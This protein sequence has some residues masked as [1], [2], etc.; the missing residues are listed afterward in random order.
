MPKT[1][2][3]ETI[4]DCFALYLKYNGE[5]LDLVEREMHDLGWVGF[6]KEILFN[7]GLGKNQRDGWI[8]RF[9]WQKSLELKIATAGIAAQTS[10]ESLLFEVETIRKKVFLEMAAT[11]V[12]NRDLVYQ[13]DKYVQRTTD[14]LAQLENARDNFGNFVFFLQ[15]LLKAASAISP[16]L[17]K[18]ICDAEDALLDWA[19]R[20]FVSS[21]SS[22]SSE[23]LES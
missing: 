1:T 19:E 9:G 7:R 3:P 15:H 18:E 5:R 16:G 22:E 12:T 2:N 8:E 13:H 23:G 21:E 6:R 14:I 10:A 17:A 20:E 11:G 4:K